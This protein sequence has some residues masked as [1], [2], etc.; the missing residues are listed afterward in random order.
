MKLFAGVGLGVVDG[1]SGWEIERK[2]WSHT[3][4]SV[5]WTLKMLIRDEEGGR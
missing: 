5:A 1:D 3:I 2:G 4:N